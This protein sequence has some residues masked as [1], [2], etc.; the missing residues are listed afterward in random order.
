MTD[1]RLGVDKPFLK[2]WREQRIRVSL[3][4]RLVLVVILVSTFVLLSIAGIAYRLVSRNI[5]EQSAQAIARLNQELSSTISL[6]LS[7]NIESVQSVANMADIR[8]L[9]GS[10]QEPILQ[11]VD[12]AYENVYLIHTIG[13]DGF[14]LAR[15]DGQSN[16]DYRD[17]NYVQAVLSGQPSA[18]EVLIGRTSQ[19]P[20]LIIALPIMDDRGRVGGVIAS[21]SDLDEISK[22]VQIS[23]FGATGYAYVLDDANRVLVHPDQAYTSELR[24]LSDYPPVVSMRAEGSGFYEFQDGEGKEWLAY[25]NTLENGWG[26][27]IQQEK[28]EFQAGLA[29]IRR[30]IFILFVLG[31]TALFVLSSV[32]VRHSMRP[33]RTLIDATTAFSGGDLSRRVVI[34][35]S[36][37]T[38]ELAA[39]FNAMASELQETLAMLEERVADRTRSL[40][41]SF[42]VSRRLASIMDIH[43]L[44]V[45]VVEEIKRIFDFYHV[46][47]YLYNETRSHLEMVGGTGEIGKQLLNNRHRIEKGKGLVGKSAETNQVVYVKDTSQEPSWLPNPLLPEAKTEIVI[48][49]SIGD[50]VLGVLDVQQNVIQ[51]I[52]PD[53]VE[54]L[55]GIANQTA[56]AAQNARLLNQAKQASSSETRANLIAQRIQSA[57]SI[58]SVLEIAVR[59]LAEATGAGRASIQVGLGLMDANQKLAAE[60]SHPNNGKRGKSSPEGMQE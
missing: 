39:S 17:R 58:E 7:L 44:V 6:W 19:Q 36:D 18:V 2:K 3:Q 52:L 41:A 26:V 54:L 48:P 15:S 13:K 23:R 49:I 56:I 29:F 21:A 14:N 16:T 9:D 20:A 4:T 37:E 12:K 57:T 25:V 53:T 10:R 31:L 30:T 32:A 5:L 60:N 24:D 59:E 11:A 43:E 8:S 42:Q 40:Q 45:E 38:G 22:S 51:E 47:I 46:H 34:E 33:I 1:T 50:T 35:R 28:G 55:Q 27:I